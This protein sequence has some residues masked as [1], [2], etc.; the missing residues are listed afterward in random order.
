MSKNKASPD[1]YNFSTVRLNN[2]IWQ[3]IRQSTKGF[4][5]GQGLSKNLTWNTEARLEFVKITY[6]FVN[7][8]IGHSRGFP[9]S[10]QLDK[11][12]ML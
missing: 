1:W 6:P 10:A 11:E 2:L 12:N 7:E 4:L 9:A 3:K 5:P 8:T